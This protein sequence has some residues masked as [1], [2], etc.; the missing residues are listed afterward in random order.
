MSSNT[1][2]T[3]NSTTTNGISSASS[4]S[5]SQSKLPGLKPPSKISKLAPPK[6]ISTATTTNSTS[7]QAQT[8]QAST[9]LSQSRININEESAEPLEDFKV[10]DKVWVNGTKP[11]VIAFIGETQFKEGIWAGIILET[12]DGKNNGTLN[13]VTYFTTEENRGVFCRL[14]KL[15]KT[16][17][18]EQTNEQAP[19]PTV[20]TS[21]QSSDAASKLKIGD[22]VNIS[23]S[24]GGI[25]TGILRYI[26]ETEF[27][28][29]EWAG[30]ELDEKLGKNDGS[31]GNKRYFQCEPMYGVFAPLQKVEPADAKP[32]Q[33][34]TTP[35]QTPKPRT[36]ILNLTSSN[37]TTGSKLNKL[38]SG[39]QESLIS[40]KSSL[41]S[42]ASAV[43]KPSL[44]AKTPQLTKTAINPV[45]SAASK[46]ATTTSAA[47]SQLAKTK[48]TTTATTSANQSTLLQVFFILAL[49]FMNE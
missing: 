16:P 1:G 8:N 21:A 42:A 45:A 5:I 22:R 6:P 17:Q 26:G 47:A 14:N 9:N 40:N 38:N 36:S 23:S 48:Q 11:G 28:K 13:G 46:T 12:A 7:T 37:A 34:A 31:V 39:S 30:V 2:D 41:I 43:N 33:A 44:V 3:T 24:V 35:F 27:A 20:S 4:S 18:L 10:D 19:Q 15:T 49:F 25:K 29:G 32:K